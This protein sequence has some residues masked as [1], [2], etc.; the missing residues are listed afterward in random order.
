MHGSLRLATILFLPVIALGCPKKEEAPAGTAPSGTDPGAAH[1]PASQPA[2]GAAPATQPGGAAPATQ[3]G[4]AATQPSGAVAP[5]GGATGAGFSGLLKLSDGLKPDAVKD[6][7]VLFIMARTRMPD[8]KPGQLV[9]VQRHGKV[10]YP[11]RYEI[12]SKDLM[13]PG[14]PFSGPFLVQARLDRDGDPMTRGAD[15]LYAEFDGPVNGGQEGVHLTLGPAP[16]AQ[17]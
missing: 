5:Q 10:A 14:T 6:S 7:D 12:T 17:K 15:D 11:F 16:T 8:G 3:P 1:P 4:G 13:M 9:A 2:G